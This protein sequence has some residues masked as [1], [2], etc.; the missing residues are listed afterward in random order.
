MKR[1]VLWAGLLLGILACAGDPTVTTESP[2]AYSHYQAGLE[3]WRRYNLRAAQEDFE[4]AVTADSSF[5]LAHLSLARTLVTIGL[6][7]EAKKSF[8][9]ALRLSP[10]ASELERLQIEHSYAVHKRDQASADKCFDL[11]LQR[12]PKDAY[13]LEVT[14][15]RAWRELDFAQAEQTYLEILAADPTRVDVHNLLGYLQLEAGRYEDA[16]ESFQRYVYY[17]PDFANPHDS[18]GDALQATG[19]YDEAIAQY[20]AALEIDPA[21]I[22]SSS[23]LAGLLAL[24]GQLNYARSLIEKSEPLFTSYNQTSTRD[25]LLMYIDEQARDWESIRD[26]A[27]TKLAQLDPEKDLDRGPALRCATYYVAALVELG[28]LDEAREARR[29]VGEIL[30]LTL[31]KEQGDDRVYVTNFV[32]LIE[33]T[34]DTRLARAAGNPAETLEPLA[35]AIELSQQS[36]HKQEPFRLELA[37]ARRTAGQNEQALA[38]LEKILHVVPSQPRANF[39]AAQVLADLGRSEDALRHLSIYFEVMS[40]ADD[41]HPELAEARQL[42][43]RFT[44]AN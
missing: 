14:A 23:Q 43:R 37:K 41:D 25:Q 9:T 1:C 33:C 8:E 38:E 15:G 29:R 17:A 6:H 11:L 4:A 3:E 42:A 36:P 35:A 16:I 22:H 7:D 18:L 13:T 44:V 34:I 12:Y 32:R 10:N 40:R 2:E 30:A 27:L 39:L 20:Q 31:E 21:F 5:A 19:Q 28:R 24:T 26:R